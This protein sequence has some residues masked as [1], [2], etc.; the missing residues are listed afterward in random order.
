MRLEGRASKVEEWLAVEP[1]VVGAE[2]L[3]WVKAGE[4]KL[5]HWWD[6][7]GDDVG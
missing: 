6:V 2:K 7:V 3:G 4:L 5:I 1:M